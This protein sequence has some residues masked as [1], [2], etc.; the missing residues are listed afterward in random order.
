MNSFNP[1]RALGFGWK[2][3]IK[4]FVA[5]ALP[6]IVALIVSVLPGAP[7]SGA[8]GVI[9]GM[10]QA[11]AQNGDDSTV[12]L[13]VAAGLRIVGSIISF[14]VGVFITAGILNFALQV[15]RGQR[16]GFGV[17][18][19]GGKWFFPML[20]LQIVAG[21]AVGLGSL[22]CLVP[23]IF[24]AL[25]FAVAQA[26]LV[27]ENLGP[28]A[29]L[30]RSWE[31]TGSAWVQILIFGILAFLVAVAGLLACCVGTF[32]TGPMLVLASVYVYL[33]LKGQEPPMPA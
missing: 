21:I 22:L 23:G 13:L 20:G 10:A 7:F 6:V 4:D 19:S 8:G 25:R 24:L 1:T 15:A 32:V 18:F 31:L 26:A 17:V 30:K 27:D 9:Q 33:T 2:V 14:L 3:V 11:A 29:A 16:P 5:V 28:I 12:L